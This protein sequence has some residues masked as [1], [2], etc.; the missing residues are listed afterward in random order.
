MEFDLSERRACLLAGLSRDSFRHPPAPNEQNVTLKAANEWDRKRSEV[1]ERI[2]GIE[3]LVPG[4]RR[5]FRVSFLKHVVREI[6][7]VTSGQRPDRDVAFP[8]DEFLEGREIF[9][10]RGWGNAATGLVG[11]QALADL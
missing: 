5:D 4:S 3:L 7:D 2:D 6:A 11:F 10:K 8:G 9:G 1:E